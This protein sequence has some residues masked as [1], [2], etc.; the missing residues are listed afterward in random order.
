M[1][2]EVVERLRLWELLVMMVILFLREKSDGKLISL[3][4]IVIGD[5]K[6][7]VLE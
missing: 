2:V 5:C 4:I 3:V 7:E 6:M 1:N